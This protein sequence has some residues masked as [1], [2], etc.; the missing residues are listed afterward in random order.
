MDER[1]IPGL[2]SWSAGGAV[3]LKAGA[4]QV[5]FGHVASDLRDIPAEALSR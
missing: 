4:D 2:H 3:T 1:A 5:S